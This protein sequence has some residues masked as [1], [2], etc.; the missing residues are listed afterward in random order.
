[1]DDE[2]RGPLYP[3]RLPTFHRFAPPAEVADRV[4]WFWVPEWDV[5]PG[6]VSR[7][8]V[9]PLP[10]LNLVVEQDAVS[11]SGPSTRRSSRDLTGRGW[12]V[13]ALLRPA[14]TPHL[15]DDP[16][17]IKDATV[18]VDA[19]ELRRAVAAEMTA[20]HDGDRRRTGAVAAAAAWIQHNVPPPGAEGR[21]AN[22]ID[23]LVRTEASI[24]RVDQVAKKL[25]VSTRTVQ[26]L[27]RRYVGLTPLAVI[28][29][30]RLQEAADR[31]RAGAGAGAG[32]SIADI[33]AELGYADHAHLA[34]AFR[35]VLGLAPSHYR[36]Q[37]TTDP[38]EPARPGE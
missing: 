19:P 29:R 37:V 22:R 20:G 12:A 17:A 10:A 8:E 35:D 31:L 15:V 13:G 24:T 11:L 7:Q 3:T 2:W 21:L 34:A 33:A 28:R 36:R 16:A 30:Y 32:A 26:R 23:T 5:A 27:A 14:A 4:A 6:R 18:T 1:M 38:P 9:L 25:G